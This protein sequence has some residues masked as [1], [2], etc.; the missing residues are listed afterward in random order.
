MLCN[1]TVSFVCIIQ[2]KLLYRGQATLHTNFTTN[3][4]ALYFYTYYS[5]ILH[6]SAVYPGHLQGVTGL[7]DV[8]SVNGN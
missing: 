5:H 7:V 4:F 2:F 8:Y 6:V 1:M 3:L